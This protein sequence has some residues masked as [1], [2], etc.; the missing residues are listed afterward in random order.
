MFKK[1]YIS[2][3]CIA[4]SLS[5][6]GMPAVLSSFGKEV[7]EASTLDDFIVCISR[8]PMLAFQKAYKAKLMSEIKHFEA[9][10]KL[11]IIGYAWELHKKNGSL[12]GMLGAII[13]QLQSF[14]AENLEETLTPEERAYF[15]ALVKDIDE[16]IYVPQ[17]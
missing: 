1:L 12:D 8:T 16:S 14:H 4:F 7:G 9:Q 17:S 5:G 2:L 11:S 10:Y 13:S 6:Y 3:F 15:E